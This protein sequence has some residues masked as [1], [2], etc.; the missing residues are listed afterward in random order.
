MKHCTRILSNDTDHL[1]ADLEKQLTHLFWKLHGANSHTV[2]VTLAPKPFYQIHTIKKYY[3]MK[4]HKWEVHHCILSLTKHDDMCPLLY[5]MT[6]TNIRIHRKDLSTYLYIRLETW[7]HRFKISTTIYCCTNPGS[8]IFYPVLCTATIN[9]SYLLWM[10]Y[11]ELMCYSS[12]RG[13]M[14][15]KCKSWYLNLESVYLHYLF[16]QPEDSLF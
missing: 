3:F 16:V 9:P 11:Q 6:L 1:G 7:K 4:M 5:N 14:N 2:H 10:L 13:C 12:F 15:T 8:N